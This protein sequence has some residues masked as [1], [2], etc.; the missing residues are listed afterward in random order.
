M[1]REDVMKNIDEM[2]G[3]MLEQRKYAIER[4]KYHDTDMDESDYDE[5]LEKI[6]Y[7]NDWMKKLIDIIEYIDT[8]EYE[9]DDLNATREAERNFI[10]SRLLLK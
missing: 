4:F 5:Q 7:L 6:A 3:E 10:L 1:K 2:F 9:L 8:L